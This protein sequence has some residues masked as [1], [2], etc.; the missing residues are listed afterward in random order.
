MWQ[1]GLGW[2]EPSCSSCARGRDTFLHT[3]LHIHL[4]F[5][6]GCTTVPTWQFLK[7]PVEFGVYGRV[8]VTAVVLLCGCA[9]IH[10]P[11]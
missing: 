5:S 10:K 3:K 4:V 6:A 9:D 11:L 7:M 8:A 2:E 1:N